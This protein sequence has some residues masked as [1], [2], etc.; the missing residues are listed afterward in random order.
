LSDLTVL[1]RKALLEVILRTGALPVLQHRQ[2]K[3]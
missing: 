2:P 3:H 1:V